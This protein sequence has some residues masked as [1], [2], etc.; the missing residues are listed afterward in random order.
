MSSGADPVRAAGGLVW[1]VSGTSGGVEVLLVHRP[2][3]DDWSFPKGK[4]EAG[5][6]EEECAVREVR[7]ETGM[8]CRRGGEVGSAVYADAQG[9]SKRVR[10][11]EMEFVSGDFLPNEEVDAIRWLEIDSAAEVLSYATDV[12]ALLSLGARLRE[13]RGG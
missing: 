1:R 6:S 3:Y 10:Y 2:R 11:W 12:E 13:S 5:E 7:E 8:R 4:L 9:R